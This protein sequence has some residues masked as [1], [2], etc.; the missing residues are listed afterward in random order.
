MRLLVT[1]PEPDATRTANA[2]EALGHAVVRSPLLSMRETGAPLP[3][4][5]FSALI[6]TSSNAVRALANHPERPL[7]AHLPV[8]AVG[9]ETAL[10]AKRS[11][12][13]PVTSAG[14]NAQDLHELA[15]QTLKPDTG[16]LLYLA[17]D[18]MGANLSEGLKRSGF[19]VYVTELYSMDVADR[20]ADEAATALSQGAI[21]A[22]L[23]Y[24]RRTASAF[25]LAL[26]RHGLSPL[27]KSVAC[28]CLSS[29]VADPIAAHTRGPIH[30]AQSPNQHAL[31]ALFLGSDI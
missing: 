5:V 25:V 1:R 16:P 7:V 3:K 23:L 15:A 31:F 13:D 27:D 10:L 8:L 12:F 29:A 17:G 30:V 24:S 6:L 2:L 28:Y 14:G 22:I 19:E 18:V 9:D 11:G 4:R 26:R 20:L 21:D